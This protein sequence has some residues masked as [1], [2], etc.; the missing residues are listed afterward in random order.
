MNGRRY[1]KT[2]YLLRCEYPKCVN[3]ELIQFNKEKNPNSSMKKWAEDLNSHFPKED[4][5]MVERHMKKYSTS[6]ITRE[7]QIK[8]TMTYHLPPKE[9]AIVGKK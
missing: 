5:Q 8:I 6:L 4:I 7:M 3:K 2:T 9:K 1:L